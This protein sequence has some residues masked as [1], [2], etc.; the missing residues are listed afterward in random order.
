MEESRTKAQG[1][2]GI[3]MVL[4]VIILLFAGVGF[5]ARHMNIVRQ[6][7]QSKVPVIAR[8]I[9]YAYGVNLRYPSHW[10]FVG[11]LA[12]DRYEGED[13]FFSVGAGGTGNTTLDKVVVS[14]V[15]NPLKPYGSEPYT[16]TLDI[17]G[18][19]GRLIMPSPDQV[20]S[21]HGQAVLVVPYPEPKVIGTQTY[22]F[23]ILWA[24]RNNIQ[25]II[26]SLTFIK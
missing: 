7:Q 15:D 17:D 6:D 1:E 3:W 14:E 23:L 21:M 11:G 22:S 8:Y 10:K 26:S 4:I 12:Y 16:Q 25:D 13:G 5:F 18:Q 9:N 19:K 2:G 24:D 20:A